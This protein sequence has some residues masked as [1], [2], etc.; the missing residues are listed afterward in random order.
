MLCFIY[1][2]INYPL[3]VLWRWS[4]GCLLEL[5]MKCNHLDHFLTDNLLEM[6]GGFQLCPKWAASQIF[7][8]LSKVKMMTRS[9][10]MFC[11]VVGS[12]FHYFHLLC[13]CIWNANEFWFEAQQVI[14]LQLQDFGVQ[15]CWWWW[16]WWCLVNFELVT[17]LFMIQPS[18]LSSVIFHPQCCW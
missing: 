15:L 3:W 8:L 16:W 17:M 2:V 7:L 10:L 6:S 1:Y 5:L 18:A 9:I 14:C 4:W 12:V 13:L 11:V